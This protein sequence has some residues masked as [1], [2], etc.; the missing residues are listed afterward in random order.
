MPIE[1]KE[2]R[3]QLKLEDIIGIVRRA[4]NETGMRIGLEPERQRLNVTK[5]RLFPRTVMRIFL[6]GA[7]ERGETDELWYFVPAGS[8]KLAVPLLDAIRKYC[9]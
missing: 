2:L 1:T 6:D 8:E 5:G 3:A 4:S 7:Y 9:M